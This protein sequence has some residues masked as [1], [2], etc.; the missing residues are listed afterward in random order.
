[1]VSSLVP[2]VSDRQAGGGVQLSIRPL[3]FNMHINQ[4]SLRLRT[5]PQ[6][7]EGSIDILVDAVVVK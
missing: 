1:M 2:L 5:P 4:E 3:R 6:A 7:L